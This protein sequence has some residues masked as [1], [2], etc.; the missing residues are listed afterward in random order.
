M[1]TGHDH[2]WIQ[3]DPTAFNSENRQSPVADEL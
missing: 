3:Y 1:N 2:H